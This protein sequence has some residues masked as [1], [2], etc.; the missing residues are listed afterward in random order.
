MSLKLTAT[1]QGGSKDCINRHSED[2]VEEVNIFNEVPKVFLGRLG[3]K[4]KKYGF[5]WKQLIAIASCMAML[6]VYAFGKQIG[7][8][9]LTIN[10]INGSRSIANDLKQQQIANFIKGND[11]LLLNIHVTH[12]AGTFLCSTMRLVGPSPAFACMFPV[13]PGGDS[14][15]QVWPPNVS[16]KRTYVPYNDT[17]SYVSLFRP[18]FYYMSWEFRKWGNLQPTNWEYEKLIS[19]IV[20]RDPIERF[21]AGGKCG[22]FHEAIHEDPTN[23]TQHLYWEYANDKCS[24]NYALRVLTD[25]AGYVMGSNTTAATLESAKTLLKRFTFVLDQECL[26]DSVIALNDALHLNIT[27]NM[28]SKTSRF[29]HHHTLSTR[30][31]IG[32]DTLYDFLQDRFRRDIELYE[33]SKTIS[34]LKCREL[35]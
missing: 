2:D 31:R 4:R 15:H 19:M 17:E 24:D 27:E 28:S 29:H 16:T 5:V 12:H 25:N 33:W 22:R 30:E 26:E 13:L 7:D 9:V 32:N 14:T 3:D 1:S 8:I 6:M 23:E 10:M 21:L 20:M 18:Y 34:I 35:I 11:T